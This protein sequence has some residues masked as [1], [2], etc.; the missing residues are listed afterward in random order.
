MAWF[1]AFCLPQ[2]EL[3]AE[4]RVRQQGFAPYLPKTCERGHLRPLFPRYLFVESDGRWRFLNSTIGISHAVMRGSEPAVVSDAVI[5]EIKKRENEEGIIELSSKRFKL[6][7]SLTLRRGPFAHRLVIYK[8]Q[9]Q[10]ERH[11]VLL[12]MLGRDTTVEVE[13]DMLEESHR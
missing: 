12:Q 9:S 10:R 3:E 13:D 5:R 6:G 7:Q 4:K 2:R 1:L 11:R 8:G